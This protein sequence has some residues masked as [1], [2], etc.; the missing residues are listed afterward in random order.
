M[1]KSKSVL[2]DFVKHQRGQKTIGGLEFNIEILTSGHWP[3]QAPQEFRIPPQIQRARDTF[4]A[5]Y[6][7]KFANRT[8][9]WLYNHG[10]VQVQTTYLSRDYQL[11]VN[12]PQAAILSMF[13]KHD[14]LT[15]KEIMERT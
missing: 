9:I 6:G 7:Q 5:F 4:I 12:G 2:E 8:L 1:I 13:N 14:V 3:Y 11:V 10:T 15:K